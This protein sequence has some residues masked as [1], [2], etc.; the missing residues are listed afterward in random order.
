M[1]IVAVTD[2]LQLGFARQAM[3]GVHVQGALEPVADALAEIREV[4]YVVLTAGRY[5]LLVEVVCESDE[6]LLEII[7]Q[8]DPRH[9]RR[10]RHRDARLP[11]AAQADVLVGSALSG[12]ATASSRS[13]TTAPATTG[14]RARRSPATARPTSRSSARATPA[15]GRRTTWPRRTRRCR[16]WSSSPRSP[17][18]AP[19][20]ATAAG[21]RR[22][23]R[24]S[25]RRWPSSAA[26]RPRWPSTRRCGPRVDEV[27]RVAAAEGI[28][29]HVAKGGTIRLA[30]GT[31]AADPRPARG[32]RGPRVGTRRRRPAAARRRRGPRRAQRRRR[33]RRR[34]TPPTAR[35]STPRGWCAGWPSPSNG[36]GSPSTSR[37]GSPRSRPA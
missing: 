17:A 25:C 37:P 27:A 32:R 30:R 35:P 36:A 33:L 15:S 3:V 19:P 5:D 18:S 13:G 9:P 20:D 16:S 28:D 12:G 14:R 11:Q 1:Q 22:C 23:S 29:A 7:S 8:P 21:A 4:D 24:P 31:S 26:A 34:S 10:D 6:H 2:P